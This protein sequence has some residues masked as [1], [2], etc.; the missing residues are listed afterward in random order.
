MWGFIMQR[1]RNLMEI[2]FPNRCIFCR[3]VI[4]EAQHIA[5]CD[6][7]YQKIHD[8]VS[9]IS[10]LKI[11]PDATQLEGEELKMIALLP[12]EGV[13]RK[14]ILR[15]KYGKVRKYAKVF[16]SL[17]IEK[18]IFEDLEAPILVPIPLAASRQRTRG[19]NQSKDLAL[20]IGKELGLPTVDCL[21]RIRDTKPQTACTKQERYKN[22]QGSMEV[23]LKYDINVKEV[24]LIDDIYTTGSTIKEAISTLK[25]QNIFKDT[26]ILIIVIGKGNL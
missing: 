12:Y 9:C 10:K 7:C 14:A 20:C 24:I 21:K 8:E 18:H 11:R 26:K 4:V 13:Y 2:V 5:V 16:A 3:K 23:E 15:W 22:L 1:I 25:K 17:L 19:F 6:R